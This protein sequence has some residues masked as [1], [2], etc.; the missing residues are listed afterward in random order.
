MQT[1]ISPDGVNVCNARYL[2]LGDH[3][4]V[5]KAALLK[6]SLY[7]DVHNARRLRLAGYCA[8]RPG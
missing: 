2:D 3:V 5:H 8:R 1:S 6:Q 4:G 7:S